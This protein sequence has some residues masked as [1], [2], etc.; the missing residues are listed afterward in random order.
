MKLFGGFKG[1]RSA[2]RQKQLPPENAEELELSSEESAAPA[3]GEDPEIEAIIAAYQKKKRTRRFI[4]LGV[5]AVLVLGGA[6]LWKSLVKPPE[7]VQPTEKPDNPGA[8]VSV[9]PTPG[10]TG[11]TE[12]DDPVVTPT[13]KR[14]RRENVYTFLLVGR[15]QYAG[16]TDTLMVGVFDA[17]AGTVDVVSIPRDTCANVESDPKQGQTKKINSVYA[18]AE[19]E[20]LVEAISDMVGFPIDCYVSVGINGFINLV[21]TI[22][23]VTFNIPY[24]MNYDD[25]TQDLH[26]HFS[27]GEQYLNGYDAIKVVR[28]RQNNDGSNYGDI[29]RIQTQQDFLKTVLKQCLSMSNLASNLDDYVDIFKEYV[30]TDLT[31]GNMAWFAKEFL[32][33]DMENVHFYT[34]PSYYNDW[35]HGFSYGTIY[36]DEWLELLNEH[37]N[38]YDQPITLE[39]IDVISRDENGELYATSGVIRGGEESFL[40]YEDWLAQYERWIASLNPPEESGEES[41]PVTAEEPS[42]GEGEA[43]EAPAEVPAEETNG[44]E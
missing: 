33:L 17:S 16:N 43:S 5:V 37:L 40:R 32:K 25:P 14:K 28:W 44:G 35:I 36:V 15:E 22:G 8:A 24:Y 21:N 3:G 7:I 18:R 27:P 12:S 10:K 2:G 34:L 4:A 26:I 1:E 9:T 6:I 13:P 38:V 11:G 39:D 19:M 30:N 41:V 20:G 29:A 31:T 42:A 23:G